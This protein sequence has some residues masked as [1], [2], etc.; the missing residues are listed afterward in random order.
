MILP[1]IWL[2]WITWRLLRREIA[3]GKVRNEDMAKSL[4]YDEPRQPDESRNSF[5]AK[6]MTRRAGFAFVLV[7]MIAASIGIGGL[8]WQRAR[9]RKVETDLVVRPNPTTLVRAKG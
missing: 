8:L 2:P 1:P 6:A 7:V 5:G 4:P 3:R 9:R